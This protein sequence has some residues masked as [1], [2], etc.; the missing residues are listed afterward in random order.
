MAEFFAY[1]SQCLWLKYTGV[2]DISKASLNTR[3]HIYAAIS[4]LRP[5][6]YRNTSNFGNRVARARDIQDNLAN[7]HQTPEIKK[8]SSVLKSKRPFLQ[9]TCLELSLK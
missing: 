8:S 9:T 6:E 7:C 4:V 1:S 3:I 5:V 2:T